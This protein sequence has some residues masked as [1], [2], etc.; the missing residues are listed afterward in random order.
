MIDD[1]RIYDQHLTSSQRNEIFNFDT[2]PLI[3]YFGEE[4]S[5]QIETIKGPTE[6]SVIGLP[7]GLEV[8]ST[9][10]LIFG[11]RTKPEISPLMLQFPTHRVRTIRFLM[12][13]L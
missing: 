12:I 1:F 4:F 3:A 6:Y 5:Y 8:D 2:P 7:D 10:G 11:K 9:N 13:P